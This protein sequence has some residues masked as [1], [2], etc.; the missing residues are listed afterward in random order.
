MS[1]REAKS[2]P[3]VTRRNT[4]SIFLCLWSNSGRCGK[5]YFYMGT[6]SL[7]ISGP[8]P[9]T[10]VF[11]FLSSNFSLIGNSNPKGEFPLLLGFQM[12][13][14]MGRN[15]GLR[16]ST[17][18]LKQVKDREI[19]IYIDRIGFQDLFCIYGKGS[20]SVSLTTKWYL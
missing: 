15:W 7:Y 14:P 11:Y 10:F 4:W 8:Q 6:L 20:R 9:R 1:F 2:T 5:I 13:Y 17:P 12:L 19:E 16:I 3:S 18:F